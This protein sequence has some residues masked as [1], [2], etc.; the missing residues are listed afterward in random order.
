[1]DL[2]IQINKYKLSLVTVEEEALRM[3]LLM[4]EMR[5]K[6]NMLYE[7]FTNTGAY[8][9]IRNVWDLRK[10]VADKLSL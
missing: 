9:G 10:Q 1:M 3:H 8:F 5:N 2:P 6:A 7:P 4:K